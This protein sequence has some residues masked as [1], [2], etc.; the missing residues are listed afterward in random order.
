VQMFGA[1]RGTEPGPFYTGLN[2]EFVV[3]SFCI[4]LA[5]PTSTSCIRTVALTFADQQGVLIQLDNDTHGAAKCFNVSWCSCYPDEAER[6]FMASRYPLRVAAVVIV[7]TAS[8]LAGY[9]S[10]M[11]KFDVMLSGGLLPRGS[12][13]TRKD[14]KN[15]EKLCFNQLKSSGVSS[16]NIP[17]YISRCFSMW[18]QKRKEI[19]I[20]IAYRLTK[21]EFDGLREL[22]MDR[23]VGVDDDGNVEDGKSMDGANELKPR[24]FG[25]FP[26]LEKMKIETK[27]GGSNKLHYPSSINSFLSFINELDESVEYEIGAWSDDGSKTWL[28]QAINEEIEHV[29]DEMGWKIEKR[30]DL[31]YQKLL[32]KKL[33]YVDVF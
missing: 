17:D 11:F 29:F 2:R 14:V 1:I 20:D 21:P 18:C 13:I 30:L 8:N 25:M 5:A 23:V 6:L 3:A 15:I 31:M 10:A 7:Q 19:K 28:R 22:I 12:K 9:F 4:K 26:N 33:K 16:T 24:I 32:F 27:E